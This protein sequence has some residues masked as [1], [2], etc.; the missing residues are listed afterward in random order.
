[1]IS[2][3]N[4]LLSSRNPQYCFPN[5]GAREE[6]QLSQ[7]M[8]LV[9]PS[10]VQSKSKILYIDMCSC[11]HIRDTRTAPS[12]VKSY[13]TIPVLLCQALPHKKGYDGRSTSSS[14]NPIRGDHPL[15]DESHLSAIA[16]AAVDRSIGIPGIPILP[17]EQDVRRFLYEDITS[18]AS[19]TC[20]KSSGGRETLGPTSSGTK[21]KSPSS[22]SPRTF[23]PSH[24][25]TNRAGPQ[26]PRTGTRFLA[27]VRR[28]SGSEATSRSW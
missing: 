11:G 1:M 10:L 25:S 13:W 27:L 23:S 3:L 20:T 19:T 2:G 22:P 24:F 4:R 6:T 15:G 7:I 16:K 5:Q 9:A 12:G 28:L 14:L 18:T 8:P 17:K 26:T 21:T